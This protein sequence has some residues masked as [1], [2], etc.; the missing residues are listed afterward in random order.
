MD[1][2]LAAS[3]TMMEG[4]DPVAGSLHKTK[5]E[6]LS[7]LSRVY[8]GGPGPETETNSHPLKGVA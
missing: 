5:P 6:F 1:F 7:K 3:D 2:S 8:R 4:A